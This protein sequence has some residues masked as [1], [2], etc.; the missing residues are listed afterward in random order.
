VAT[1]SGMS[2]QPDDT[3]SMSEHI[4]AGAAQEAGL[5]S[6]DTSQ[7]ELTSTQAPA[8]PAPRDPVAGDR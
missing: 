2:E 3:Q 1:V 7:E 5:P 4:S 8:Q 6:D